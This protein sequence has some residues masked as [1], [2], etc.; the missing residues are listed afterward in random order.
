MVLVVLLLLISTL[1]GSIRYTEKFV[2]P[3]MTVP[4]Q[5]S[6]EFFEEMKMA[7]TRPTNIEPNV[8]SEQEHT[9]T[10]TQTPTPNPASISPFDKTVEYAS[11]SVSL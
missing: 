2:D 11:V 7:R 10:Y 3:Y 5:E 1:G 8:I 4:M 6:L 9:P